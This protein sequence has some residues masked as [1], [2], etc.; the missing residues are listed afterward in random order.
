LTIAQSKPLVYF[1]F[2]HTRLRGPDLQATAATLVMFSIG[3]FAWG[4]Q[5]ILARGF[6]AAR[7]TLTP[8]IVGTLLT[9]L[10]LPVYWILAHRLQHLGLALASSC[11]IIAYTSVLFVLLTRRT[12]NPEAGS[13]LVFSLKIGIASAIVAVLCH[14][15]TEW[16]GIYLGWQKT[17]HA[18]LV[19][20]I[21]S[22][23]GLVLTGLLARL[24]RVRELDA[25]LAKLRFPWKPQ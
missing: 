3:M 18:L 8:A 13:L 22:S 21:V 6:Y 25:Y 11:G 19:L 16:L 15:L 7:D 24:L 1:V 2:S 12:R 4:A 17:L 23:V 10:N 14:R 5:N 20:V 9:F